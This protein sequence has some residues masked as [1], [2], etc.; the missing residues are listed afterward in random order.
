MRLENAVADIVKTVVADYLNTTSSHDGASGLDGAGA[1]E[2]ALSSRVST[3]DARSFEECLRICFEHLLELLRRAHA[4]HRALAAAARR[5]GTRK[6]LG[7]TDRVRTERDDNG[8][9]NTESAGGASPAGGGTAGMAMGETNADRGDAGTAHSDSEEL[10]NDSHEL[11]RA[12]CELSQK[13]VAQLLILRKEARAGAV[14]SLREVERWT[15]GALRVA[16]PSF[17]ACATGARAA[18]AA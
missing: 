6:A 12:V 9:P 11:L 4:A 18:L 3:L 15:T 16:L 8:V 7:F 13:S 1:A 5:P 17:G 10:I 14:S 2:S